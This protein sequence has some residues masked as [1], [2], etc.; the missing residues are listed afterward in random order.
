MAFIIANNLFTRDS[1]GTRGTRLSFISGNID[2]HA[3]ELEIEAALLAWAQGASAA[4]DDALVAQTNKIGEKGT[5]FQASQDADAAMLERYV[6][7]RKLLK[8]RYGDDKLTLKEF[9]IAGTVPQNNQQRYYKAI[10]LIEKNAE[11]LAAG[12]PRALPAG[13]VASLVP[14]ADNVETE[15]KLALEAGRIANDTTKAL[16]D[17]FDAD[18]VQ[19]RILYNW[20]V[21]YWGKRNPLL[22]D[23]G[24][25]QAKAHH[26]GQPKPPE[27]LSY[28]DLNSVFS[29]DAVE[30][31]TSYQC[32]MQT[33]SSG[34]NS[35]GT[36]WNEIY[37]GS[38]TSFIWQKAEGRWD[39]RVR[40]RNAHGFGKWGDEIEVVV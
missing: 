22:I 17:L 21:S 9:G 7:L 15:Y 11:R 32:E 28:D 36:K 40:A 13:M 14:L 34:A 38:E 39:V 23:L 27:N 3:A 20:C 6:Q 31:A 10:E 12:D 30:R 37:E 35:L 24:F 26:R 18:S 2:M 1:R 25:V 4:Y 29:W 33:D 5:A 8:S 16:N 19:L